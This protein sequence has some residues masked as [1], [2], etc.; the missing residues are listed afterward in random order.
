MIG[1]RS[2]NTRGSAELV[3]KKAPRLVLGLGLSGLAS[4]VEAHFRNLGWE[5]LRSDDG[6]EA[7]R[8]AHRMRTTAVVLSMAPATESGLLT[9]AKIRLTRPTARVVLV[10]PEGQQF[11]RYARFAGAVGYVPDSASV[12]AIARAV[13]GN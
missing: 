13:L 7:G 11:A 8:Q 4:A 10:G 3:R 1:T 12:A 6:D 9:C 2:I 5:V